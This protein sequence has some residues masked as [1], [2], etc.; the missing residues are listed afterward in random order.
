M[1]HKRSPNAAI[2]Q[3]KLLRIDKALGMP[4]PEVEEGPQGNTVVE[5]FKYLSDGVMERHPTTN[6]RKANLQTAFNAITVNAKM[7]A[8]SGQAPTQK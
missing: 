3:A 8:A 5:H 7:A 2:L 4:V 6:K 1:L